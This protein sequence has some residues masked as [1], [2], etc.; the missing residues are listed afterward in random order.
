MLVSKWT[1][2]RTIPDSLEITLYI[3]SHYP[4]LLPKEQEAQIRRLM[5]ELHSL[6]YFSL[7]FP[8]RPSIAQGLKDTVLLRLNRTDISDRHRK[9]LEYK[10]TV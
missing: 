4:R 5:A 6:N 8:D 1:P 7:S 2:S 9:A 3:S 10:L